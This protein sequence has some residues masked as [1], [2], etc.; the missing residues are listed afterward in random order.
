[1]GKVTQRR[2][3]RR[4]VSVSLNLIPLHLP[5]DRTIVIYISPVHRKTM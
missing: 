2:A 4:L 1:M 5:V 3:E